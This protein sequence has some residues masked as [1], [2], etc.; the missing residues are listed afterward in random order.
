MCIRDRYKKE[1][2]ELKAQNKELAELTAALRR[3]NSELK[4]RLVILLANQKET[5]S[6]PLEISF[7]EKLSKLED[8]NLNFLNESTNPLNTNNA[9][10]REDMIVNRFSSD[11]GE[12]QDDGQLF[13]LNNQSEDEY[14]PS[15]VKNLLQINP[16]CAIER[17]D[18]AGSFCCPREEG[19]DQ[20]KISNL[21]ASQ[22]THN[23]TSLT[24]ET[25]ESDRP[26]PSSRGRNTNRSKVITPRADKLIAGLMVPVK[27]KMLSKLNRGRN[28]SP[29]GSSKASK[30]PSQ[31]LS[32]RKE[33]PE[34]AFATPHFC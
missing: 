26:Y 33:T 32:K 6:E 21:P 34:S 3:E 25:L 9:P 29:I 13:E 22:A 15:Y 30:S 31:T 2:N 11:I 1:L 12:Y 8:A 19:K 5:T 4:E 18:S 14:I 17:N 16:N 27:K 20:T 28:T 7:E 23:D 24:D 10:I